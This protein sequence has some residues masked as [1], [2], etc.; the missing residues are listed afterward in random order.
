[1]K[2]IALILTL[3]ATT[4][5]APAYIGDLNFQQ[6]DGDS[7]KGSI[8]G[9]EWFNWIE[10]KKEH[11]VKFSTKSKNFEYAELKEINGELDLAPSGIKVGSKLGTLAK[12]KSKIDKA[13][14]AD[15]WKQ[16]RAKAIKR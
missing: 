3:T 2:K 5:A 7:F 10:D 8:H 13:T 1:M 6:K 9:D 4:Y 12:D 14:L 11:I 15:I 16:K